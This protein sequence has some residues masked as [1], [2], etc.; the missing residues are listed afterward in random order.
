W[1]PRSIGLTNPIDL[2]GDGDGAWTSPRAHAE[3][4]IARVGTAP[5]SLLEALRDSDEAI[6]TQAA[7]LCRA[8]GRDVRD[9]EFSR[10]LATSPEPVR[11]GFAAFAATLP[12]PSAVAPVRGA[13]GA[14]EPV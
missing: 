1:V 5:G 8:A 14:Q 10:L 3:A 6:A 13:S 7:D 12:A 11:R 9:A 4:T 2:D